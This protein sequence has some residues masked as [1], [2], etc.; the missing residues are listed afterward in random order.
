MVRSNVAWCDGT[1]ASPYDPRYSISFSALSHQNDS[2]ITTALSLVRQH[3][4]RGRIRLHAQRIMRDEADFAQGR[5][6]EVAAGPLVDGVLPGRKRALGDQRAGNAAGV[7]ADLVEL[8]SGKADDDLVLHR[9]HLEQAGRRIGPAGGL[10][11]RG[12][13]CCD[14]GRGERELDQATGRDDVHCRVLGSGLRGCKQGRDDGCRPSSLL[15]RSRGPMGSSAIGGARA[16][17]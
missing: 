10:R 3:L 11:K 12:A 2:G 16:G 5:L 6:L 1:A 8:R 17:P 4:E 9:H 7:A 15:G 14:D 13:G